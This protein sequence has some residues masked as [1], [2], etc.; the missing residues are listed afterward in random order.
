[1]IGQVVGP[2]RI[3]GQIGA[4]GMGV[5]YL[6]EHVT[7]GGRAAV[8]VLLPEYSQNQDMVGRIFAE[9]RAAALIDHPGMV[10]VYDHGRMRNGAAYIVMEL[11][12]GETL[13]RRLRRERRLGV[14]VAVAIVRQVAGAVGA[15]HRL[16]IVHR[17]LKPDNIYLISDPEMA[18]GVRAKVLD[19]GI[20][21]LAGDVKPD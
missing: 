12:T 4:G 10:R 3:V 8:K 20:A 7:L 17:D 9:A 14:E 1:M 2:Y 15:A 13:A 11:L 21:K 18:I 16:G 5:V 6:A 19:F